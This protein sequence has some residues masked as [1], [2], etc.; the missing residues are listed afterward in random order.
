MM[1]FSILSVSVFSAISLLSGAYPEPRWEA[2]TSLFIVALRRP[3]LR[4]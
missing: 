1:R 2:L 4:T 3:S